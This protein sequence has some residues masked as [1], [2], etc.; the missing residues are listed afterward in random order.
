MNVESSACDTA[1]PAEATEDYHQPGEKLAQS[2]QT[3]Q[4]A[5]ARVVTRFLVSNAAAGSVIGKG[6]TNITEYQSKTGARIQLSRSG[7]VFPGTYDRVMLLAG[8]LRQVGVLREPML[9]TVF[10]CWACVDISL[11]AGQLCAPLDVE[12][13]SRRRKRN[14]RELIV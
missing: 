13:A 10:S 11:S 14:S 12:Q 5:E 3:G 9:C 4:P 1:Q 6:G 8:T 2:Q 7:E